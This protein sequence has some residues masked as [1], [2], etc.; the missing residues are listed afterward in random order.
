VDFTSGASSE[1]SVADGTTITYGSDG[2]EFI[3]T[4]DGAARTITSNNYIF[5]GKVEIVLKAANGT[6]VVS[7]FVME[8]DDLDEIDW[9]CTPIFA[10]FEALLQMLVVTCNK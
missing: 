2:A 3:M 10:C 5:F 8:S 7:S 1:F 4:S 9:V 6:G